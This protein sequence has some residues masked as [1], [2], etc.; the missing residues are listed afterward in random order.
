MTDVD[1][2][3][4]ISNRDF[5][6][7][8]LALTPEEKE[9][10][11]RRESAKMRA[12]NMT[13]EQR[14]RRGPCGYIYSQYGITFEEKEAI[15]ASQG[16]A[17]AICKTELLLKDRRTHI[18]HDHRTGAVRGLLCSDCNTG[19]GFYKD[20]PQY[21]RNAIAYLEREPA[22]PGKSKKSKLRTKDFAGQK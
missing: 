17:C 16:F 5:L 13:A 11:K 1:P 4:Y 12:K 7:S 20:Q 10:E 19:L 22:H 21:L 18:D 6:E 14:K 2:D 3:W 15:L 9:K 8:F